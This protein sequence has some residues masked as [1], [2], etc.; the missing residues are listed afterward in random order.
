M[1][2]MVPT[3]SDIDQQL[4]EIATVSPEPIQEHWV[5]VAGKRY[6]PKQVYQLLT[7]KPRATFTSHRALAHLRSLGLATSVYRP[8]SK[9]PI[10]SSTHLDAVD[11]TDSAASFATLLSFLSS[12][13]L[14]DHLA[15]AESTLDGADAAACSDVVEE[16]QFSEDLLDAALSVRKHV[17]RLSDVIHATTITPVPTSHPGEWRDRDCA[18]VPG[19][20]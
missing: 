5:E 12:N 9:A 1:G 2:T 8:S 18:P 19:C 4:R 17:G 13:A 16:F 14:T 20:G 10:D 15:S 11:G 6:P 7:N 3:E